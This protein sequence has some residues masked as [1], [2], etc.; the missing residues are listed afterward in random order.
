MIALAGATGFIGRAVRDVLRMRGIKVVT[1]GRRAD[2][3]IRWPSGGGEFSPA[4]REKL[5]RTRAVVNLCGESIGSRWTPARRRAIRESRAGLTATLVRGITSIEPRPR[6]LLSASA[7][8]FYGE[9]GDDWL[10]ESEPPG[11]D[12]LASVAREWEEA[13]SPAAA[14]EIRVVLMR[15]GVVFGA[16]GGML[17]RLRLPFSL[18]AGAKLGSGRQWM[19]WIA[20]EDVVSFVVR[21]IDDDGFEGPVNVTSPEPLTNGE[22]TSLFARILGRPAFLALPAA[23][24]RLGFGDMADGVL[25]ASQ[26]ARPSCLEGRGFAY[27]H[28]DAASALRAAVR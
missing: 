27:V 28:P 13:T 8:G 4:D 7:V 14:A 22:F 3:D 23:A 2:A 12:F 17:S 19:S 26:R 24:L 18:G 11:P 16:G 25:L 10:D 6:V 15:M 20:L 9:R 1:I 21:A 5:R